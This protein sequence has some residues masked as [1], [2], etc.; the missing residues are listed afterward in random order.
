MGQTPSPDVVKQGE[1]E[2]RDAKQSLRSF[3]AYCTLDRGR[4]SVTASRL[5]YILADAVYYNVTNFMLRSTSRSESVDRGGR[6]CI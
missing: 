1:S 4:L 5:H 2:G 3:Q 6:P